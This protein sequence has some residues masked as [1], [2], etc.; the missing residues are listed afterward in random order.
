[1]GFSKAWCGL[2]TGL[3]GL[4]VG[5]VVGVTWAASS[6][7]DSSAHFIQ[8]FLNNNINLSGIT[9][10]IKIGKYIPVPVTAEV[11]ELKFTLGKAL[12]PEFVKDLSSIPETV[13]S[14]GIKFMGGM[15][16]GHVLFTLAAVSVLGVYTYK[17]MKAQHV[18][19]GELE[20]NF[21]EEKDLELGLTPYRAGR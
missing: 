6:F 9:A 21:L 8:S 11:T 3:S 16:V 12:D 18:P 20:E 10:K 4:A 13:V 1:M 7:K 17:K 19:S 5:G 2:F 14:A 15:E